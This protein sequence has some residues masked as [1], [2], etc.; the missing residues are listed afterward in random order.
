MIVLRQAPYTNFISYA[1][2]ASTEYKLRIEDSDYDVVFEDFITSTNTGAL[3]VG[4]SGVYGEDDI[5][6]DFTKYDDTYHL[7]ITDD[8]DV[9]VQ[10]N[11]TVERPYVDPNTLG[12]T[13]LVVFILEPS[14][15]KQLDK[16]QTI[17]H[18]G[19][20]SIKS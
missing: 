1:L 20:K 15:L 10:D 5:P 16:A 17:C 13:R 3:T 19:I 12:E 6:Y 7:E 9:V 14:G 8:T 18:F 4:W 2:T 11:L